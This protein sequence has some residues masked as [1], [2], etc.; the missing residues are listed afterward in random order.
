MHDIISDIMYE[1]NLDRSSV[2]K[3]AIFHFHN[4]IQHEDNAH[5]DNHELVKRI[6]SKAVDSQKLYQHYSTF[7]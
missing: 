5:L 4:F 2:L 3:L 1:R 7:N 6:N